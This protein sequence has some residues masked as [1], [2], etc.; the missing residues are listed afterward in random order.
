MKK[1]LVFFALVMILSVDISLAAI[2]GFNKDNLY[3]GPTIGY[4][5]YLYNAS[6]GFGARGEYG[7]MD[8]VDVGSF[9]GALGLGADLFY[10]SDTQG[11]WNTT[12]ISFLVY[13]SYH[14]SPKAQLDPYISA[15]LGYRNISDSYTGPY[16]DIYNY[17][18]NYGSGLAT[19]GEIGIHYYLSDGMSLRASLGYPVLLSAGVDFNLGTMGW[20]V[21]K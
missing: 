5:S 13:V 17:S 10:S 3:V 12:F 14:L 2:S 16:G 9:K 1:F 4:N 20:S 15:G 11:Y 18:Y 19:T 21:K 7:L 8:N 6:I